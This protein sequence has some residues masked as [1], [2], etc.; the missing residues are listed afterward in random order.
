[1]NWENNK[2][3]IINTLKNYD[4]QIQKISATVGPTVC[5]IRD[6]SC[7]GCAYLRKGRRWCALS[8]AALG[9]HHL[10]VPGRGTIGIMRLLMQKSVVSSRK[11]CWRFR[12]FQ[13]NKFFVAGAIGKDRQWKNFYR[14]IFT[15]SIPHLLMA[16]YQAEWKS[17]RGKCNAGYRCCIKTSFS[18]QI[19]TG[20]SQKVELSIYKTIETSRKTAGRRKMHHHHRYKKSGAHTECTPVLKWIAI[21]TCWKPVAVISVNTMKNLQHANS[22]LKKA[23]SFTILS[24]FGDWWVCRP[25]HDGW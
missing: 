11:H 10:L 5:I 3:Q 17:G 23:T 1:M 2:S 21:L 25:D 8:L 9:I 14:W 15:A 20:G 12:K 24:C 18:A 16:K 22:T 6:H 13:H 19:C 4:I 7:G